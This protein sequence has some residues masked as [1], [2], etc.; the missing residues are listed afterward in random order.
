MFLYIV[1][2]LL[3]GHHREVVAIQL[4]DL[5]VDLEAGFTSCTLRSDLRHVDPVICIA[6]KLSSLSPGNYM[7]FT[8]NLRTLPIILVYPTSNLKSTLEVCLRD[9]RRPFLVEDNGD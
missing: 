6:L 4:E 1:H 3:V 5:V 2:S 8:G 9:S 7:K